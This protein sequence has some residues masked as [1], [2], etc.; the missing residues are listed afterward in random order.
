MFTASTKFEYWR[1]Q[2]TSDHW[3]LIA[4]SPLSF[5]SGLEDAKFKTLTEFFFPNSKG[6]LVEEFQITDIPLVPSNTGDKRRLALLNGS[7]F[8]PRGMQVSG[9]IWDQPLEMIL[10]DHEAR[11]GAPSTEPTNPPA[12][13]PLPVQPQQT[14]PVSSAKPSAPLQPSSK[15]ESSSF[16]LM[17]IGGVIVLGIAGLVYRLKRGRR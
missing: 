12:T 13:K 8:K 11:K 4:V 10:K 1:Y 17:I 2:R 15:P 7:V 14:S 6:D 5:S 16:T 3:S 9:A